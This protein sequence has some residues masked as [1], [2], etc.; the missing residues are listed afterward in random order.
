MH[1]RT[2]ILVL[3]PAFL[4]AS[5]AVGVVFSLVDPL[6]VPFFGHH[7][8]DSRELVYAAGF[9]LFWAI[10]A[11]ASGLTVYLASEAK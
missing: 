10:S 6:D 7:V 2:L 11:I 9:F 4:A 8:F 5:L 1:R 3:W